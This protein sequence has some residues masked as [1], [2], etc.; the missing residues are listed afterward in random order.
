MDTPA[1][2]DANVVALRGK[3][4]VGRSGMME[5]L[6]TPLLPQS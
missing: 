4:A 1:A 2:I 3:R 5:E 6:V